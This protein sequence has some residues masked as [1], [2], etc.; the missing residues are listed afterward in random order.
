[1]RFI[2]TIMILAALAFLGVRLYQEPAAPTSLQE[3]ARQA[4]EQARQAVGAAVDA[5]ND[6]S[7]R[8]AGLVIGGMD[9]GAEVKATM[10]AATA[11]LNG[12]TDTASLP[13]AEAGL[14]V[15][16]QRVDGL[17]T[18]VEQLPAE[19]KRLLAGAVATA[20]PPIKALADKAGTVAG[21]EKLK[22]TIDAIVAELERWTKEEG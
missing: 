21:A 12:I 13:T 4:A 19:G 5:A 2:F 3:A 20:L 15:L 22:P 10:A 11:A 7:Q 8:M 6:A 9:V 18:Q 1:M 14:R 16:Q 17:T